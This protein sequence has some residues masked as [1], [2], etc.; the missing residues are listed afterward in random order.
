MNIL[1]IDNLVK[2][3]ASTKALDDVSFSVGRGEICGLLGPNGAGKTTLLRIINN[4]LV[5]DSGNV[6]INGIPASLEASRLIGY[7][8]EE[9]GLYDKMRVEDQ[10]L[11]FGQLKGGDKARLRIVMGEYMEIFNLTGQGKR[12]VKELSKGN[13]QKVQIIATL[14]HEPDLVILDEPF[15][16]FDPINGALLRDLITRL[17]EKGATIMLSSHN[18]P[19]IEEM[20]STIALINHGKLLVKGGI[21]DIKEIHKTSELLLTTRSPLSIPLL[22]DSN[23][24]ENIN[25]IPP[26]NG[27]KGYSYCLRKKENVRNT[28]LLQ[29]ISIQGEILHFEER[30]PTLNDIFLNYTTGDIRPESVQQPIETI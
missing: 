8:P 12:K 1:Q 18:M 5:Y 3:Y 28:D 16:G 9:R 23:L 15:S 29:A 25:E 11:Y 26:V 7:M 17:N 14:V 20:C 10:I 24:L 22:L 13:Q 6:T 2:H 19:A 27:R 21:S 30:L 4:L